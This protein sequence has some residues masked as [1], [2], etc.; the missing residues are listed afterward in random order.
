MYHRCCFTPGFY[1][2]TDTFSSTSK[3]IKTKKT[4][5]WK[6]SSYNGPGLIWAGWQKSQRRSK[7]LMDQP[8]NHHFRPHVIVASPDLTRHL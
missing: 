5:N 1:T 6:F 8:T 3:K 4:K 7:R 2:Y